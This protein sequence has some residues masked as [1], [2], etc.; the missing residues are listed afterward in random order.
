MNRYEEQLGSVVEAVEIR[1]SRSFAWLGQRVRALPDRASGIPPLEQRRYLAGRLTEQLY[2]DFY[3]PGSIQP[4]S[5]LSDAGPPDDPASRAFLQTLRAAHTL[6]ETLAWGW[7]ITDVSIATR[8][9]L[10]LRI[11][12]GALV[13]GEGG[14][15]GLRLRAESLGQSPGHYMIYGPAGFV[16]GTRFIRLY[17]NLTASGAAPLITSLSTALTAAGVPFQLK[18][19]VNPREYDRADAAVL[20]LDVQDRLSVMP[21]LRQVHATGRPHLRAIVP[22]LTNRIGY[23]VGLAED[24]PSGGSFGIHRCAIIAEGL[25]TAWERGERSADARLAAIQRSFEERGLHI[26]TP[27]LNPGSSDSYGD[28]L[29]SSGAASRASIPGG[30]LTADEA[31]AVARAIGELLAGQAIWH[32]DRCNWFGQAQ[33]DGDFTPLGPNLYAGTSGIALFLA[34]LHQATGERCFLDTALGAARQALHT[35]DMVPPDVRLGLYTG[36]PGIAL[37]CQVVGKLAGDPEIENAGRQL[38]DSLDLA[39]PAGWDLLSGAA[40]TALSLLL[41]QR[42]NPYCGHRIEAASRLGSALLV[43]GQTD[44]EDYLAWPPDV[45]DSARPLTGFAHG[46]AGIGH[47]L[48]ELGLAAREPRFVEGAWKAFAYERSWY[49]ETRQNWPDFRHVTSKAARPRG[50]LP[51]MAGWRHGAPG[52]ALSRLRAYQLS[53]DPNLLRDI[54]AAIQTTARAV[55]NGL[56][57]GRVGSSLCHGLTGNAEILLLA[58]EVVPLTEETRRLIHQVARREIQQQGASCAW[59]IAL[60]PLP[61]LMLGMAGRGRFLLRLARPDLPASCSHA[62]KT[63]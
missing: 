54:Q 32:A 2:R 37:A 5:S 33:P 53:G 44:G 36:T 30:G 62:P 7:D 56:A 27:Y 17:W 63:S 24:P 57:T 55:E 10:R 15:Q 16:P 43:A 14:S 26:T 4:V 49:D 34:E 42:L 46:A 61:G 6:R 47:A 58:S 20:Y 52:I 51:T 59:E 48:L 41:A 39:R 40:G 23:G 25:I 31:L 3:Q 13:D 60:C 38:L 12:P 50:P 45:A 19:P 21:Q 28:F 9:H 22:A 29:E 11:A 18:M 35:H 8:R 1:S